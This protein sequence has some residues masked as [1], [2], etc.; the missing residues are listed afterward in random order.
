M[1]PPPNPSAQPAAWWNIKAVRSLLEPLRIAMDNRAR[2]ALVPVE[3]KR[4]FSEVGLDIIERV[5]PGFCGDVKIALLKAMEI[6]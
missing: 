6:A 3:N 1:R 5:D 4:H 2:N